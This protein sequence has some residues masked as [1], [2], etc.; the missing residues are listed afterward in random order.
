[1]VKSKT[2]SQN[3]F[4]RMNNLQSEMNYKHQN[5]ND[6]PKHSPHKW[7][8]HT[9]SVTIC[10]W[11]AKGFWQHSIVCIW[12]VCLTFQFTIAIY[13][14]RPP[15]P[16]PLFFLILFIFLN[17]LTVFFSF[18]FGFSWT[19]HQSWNFLKWQKK[20]TKKKQANNKVSGSVRFAENV[21]NSDKVIGNG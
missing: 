18:D 7:I 19:N 9:N 5:A 2:H 21:I 20:P 15:P 4:I 14:P 1:M 17:L 8:I 11:L 3:P 16:P 12:L 13:T 10:C 6:K